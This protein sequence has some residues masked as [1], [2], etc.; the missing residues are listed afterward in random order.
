MN[1]KQKLRNRCV[2]IMALGLVFAATSL[3]AADQNWKG[4]SGNWSDSTGW[5]GGTWVSDSDAIFGNGVDAAGTV[6]LDSGNIS[7]NSI[8]FNIPG[9]GSYA[10]GRNTTETLT[11]SSGGIVANA[12]AAI[13]FDPTIG[14]NQ[15]WTTGSGKTLSIGT[16]TNFVRG[17]DPGETL[18]IAGA[19]VVSASGPKVL[20]NGTS[21]TISISSGTT[22][23]MNRGATNNVLSARNATDTGVGTLNITGSGTLKL[24][25]AATSADYFAGTIKLDSFTGLIEFAGNGRLTQLSGFAAGQTSG[26]VNSG[27]TVDLYNY[28]NFA[29][30]LSLDGLT[31]AGK[32]Y[33]ANG[34]AQNLSF[35]IGVNDTTNAGFGGTADWSGTL[36]VKNN[37]I[38]RIVKKGSGIQIFSGTDLRKNGNVDDAQTTI[39]DGGVLQVGNGGTSGQLGT[40]EI[41]NNATLTFKRSN[42][43]T[44]G[45]DFG[46]IR[47]SG[48]VIQ[49]GSG[50]LTFSYT[51]TYSGATIVTNGIL[52]LANASCLSSAT[53]IYIYSGA[54]NNLAFLGTNTIHSLIIDG[55]P[56][57]AGVYNADNLVGYLTGGGNLRSTYPPAPKGTMIRV[58]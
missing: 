4:G 40:A 47:G 43:V 48:Q 9:S 26:K 50:T 15:V 41:T 20:V 42:T 55:V 58:F 31:G 12:S 33:R 38:I 51:N 7:V 27:M 52:S 1:M 28:G 56:K 37:N 35:T 23:E 5:N 29:Q 45:T 25:A 6:T 17:F 44:Q 53:D 21:S 34:A 39:I 36:E 57:F 18:T 24:N 2:V 10:I 30:T 8:T 32:I 16:T 22:L 13:L 46:I 3:F 49:K 14:T 11:V 19:G 54:T